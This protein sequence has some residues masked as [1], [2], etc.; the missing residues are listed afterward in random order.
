MSVICPYCDQKAELVQGYVLYPHRQDLF[1]KKFYFCRQCSAYVGCHPGTQEPLG[2]L[3]NAELRSI[4]SQVHKVFDLI[5]KSRKKTRRQAYQWLADKLKIKNE[6]CHIAL[7]DIDMCE[8]AIE[9]IE[10]FTSKK[11]FIIEKK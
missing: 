6:N 2:T 7:F 5:W 3:A 4:R 10:Q 8:K 11:E 1:D 9:F